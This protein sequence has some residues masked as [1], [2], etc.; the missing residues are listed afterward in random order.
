MTSNRKNKRII[1]NHM[2]KTGLNF[3]EA[4]LQLEASGA[5]PKPGERA[6]S[7]V[8]D[9]SFN[10][11]QVPLDPFALATN[12]QGKVVAMTSSKGGKGKSSAAIASATYLAH[13][14]LG[15]GRSETPA[16]PLGRVITVTSSK[17]GGG[18]TTTALALGAY[19]A[20]SSKSGPYR[21]L[22]VLVL[23]L[24][25]R[26]GQIGFFTG[27]WKLTVMRLLRFGISKKEIEETVIHDE[28]LDV[29]V[30]LAPRRP[31][32]ADDLS[33]E[34]YAE[35][36][37][38][39][40]GIYDYIVLDT[41]VSYTDSIRSQV[42]Y[43]YGTTDRILVLTDTT[44]TSLMGLS[45]WIQSVA[46]P[47]D[48]GGLGVAK[49]RISVVLNR[50]LSGT[51]PESNRKVINSAMEIPIIGSIP[52]RSE[53]FRGAADTEGLARLLDDPEIRAALRRVLLSV[54]DH[55]LGELPEAEA[56]Q[57]RPEEDDRR[58]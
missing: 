18:K 5:I 1:R 58:D 28:N 37:A 56:E 34:F 49:S 48:Q 7:E 30:L 54:V 42:G 3:L 12:P 41:S 27:F 25:V 13:A 51:D 44:N 45:R 4:K 57:E 15:T 36:I 43:G 19:L 29:D 2:E 46:A 17:G 21:P 20:M 52:L 23:D 11:S 24:D 47:L 9:L 39:L 31:R 33:P 53:L 55:E 26:D 10:S 6:P 8:L 14:A 50:V 35:L 22:K 40:R 16:D 38:K 32:S